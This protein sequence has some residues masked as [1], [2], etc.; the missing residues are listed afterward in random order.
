MQ[1]ILSI[2]GLLLFMFS[3][4]LYAQ[5]VTIDTSTWTQDQKNLRKAKVYYFIYNQ[6]GINEVPQ[7][8]GDQICVTSDIVGLETMFSK[9]AIFDRIVVDKQNSVNDKAV[10]ATAKATRRT[11]LLAKYS[12]ADLDA[13]K[14][15]FEG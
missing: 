4:N 11:A 3:M 2:L 12:T 6:L 5:C 9:Q 10:E 14:E 13:M 8:S 15:Y 7:I 1:K